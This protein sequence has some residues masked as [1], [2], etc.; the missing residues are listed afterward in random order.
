MGNGCSGCNGCNGCG[1][2]GCNGYGAQMYEDLGFNGY[3]PQ[4]AYYQEN[5]AMANMNYGM[6]QGDVQPPSADP[7]VQ[8]W[9]QK[10]DERA[11]STGAYKLRSLVS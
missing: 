2:G 9:V 1:C 3:V 10:F 11:Q 4:H 5:M 7:Q 6:P 8:W